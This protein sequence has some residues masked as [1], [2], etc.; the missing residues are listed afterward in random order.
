MRAIAVVDARNRLRAVVATAAV[1]ARPRRAVAGGLSV[2]LHVA[3]FAVLIDMNV[4]SG[5]PSALPVLFLEDFSPRAPLQTS[6]R[7]PVEEAPPLASEEE[8]APPNPDPEQ[9]ADEPTI[10]AAP[11][12]LAAL[13][14]ALERSSAP[15]ASSIDTPA[16]TFVDEA[17]PLV[18]PPMPPEIDVPRTT[19]VEI[20]PAER[21]TLIERVKQAAQALV[22][23]DHSEIAWQEDGREYRAVLRRE[24]TADS[25]DLERIAAQVTTTDQGASM[26]TQLWLSRLAFSQFTQVIDRWDMKVQLHDDEFIGRFHSNSS[27]F[28]RNSA[29]ATP[30]F[31]GKVTT[32]AP[33]LRFER[34]SRRDRSEMFH[35]GLETSAQRIAFP[36]QSAPFALAPLEAD[37]H[38]QRFDDDTRIVLAGDGTYTWKARRTGEAV[39]AR[40]SPQKPLYL[41]AG[42]RSTLYVRGVVDGR[43][44]VYSPERIVIEGSLTYADDPRLNPDADDYLGLV[45]DG[46]VEIARPHVTGDGDLRIDAAIFARRQFL[47]TDFEHLRSATLWIYGSLAARTLS[48]SEPR[49]G[50]KV[51]FDPRFDR[52]RP[53]GFPSTNH[54]ELARWEPAWHEAAVTSAEQDESVTYPDSS[55]HVGL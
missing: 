18:A 11:T 37:A 7:R 43:M 10:D 8:S 22:D 3:L 36:R 14:D 31:I 54:F 15:L 28:I 51:E 47:V 29:Q 13:Q 50:M 23:A 27:F 26:Q 33:R 16:L 38:V 46:S 6:Q 20:A 5:D 40:Y 34:V 49:Y 48:A 52:V 17:N 41:L 12:N 1:R 30:K 9:R 42:R 25:M 2:L 55:R 21:A 44:L 45:S 32:A 24:V 53:P 4:R 35:G 39:R 19:H